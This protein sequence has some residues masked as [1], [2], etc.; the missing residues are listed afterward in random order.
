MKFSS[1]HYGIAIVSIDVHSPEVPVSSGKGIQVLIVSDVVLLNA[2]S[3]VCGY[4]TV[5]KHLAKTKRF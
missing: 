4:G 3:F 2:I 1:F 5:S